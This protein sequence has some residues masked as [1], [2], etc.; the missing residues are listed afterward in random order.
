MRYEFSEKPERCPLCS[1]NRIA[2]VQY[3]L[4]DYSEN[5]YNKVL[6]GE[7]VIGGTTQ[8]DDAAAWQCTKCTLN[9]HKKK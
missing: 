7:I 1:H 3:G 6:Y 2:D 8:P 4:P 9:I 5:I